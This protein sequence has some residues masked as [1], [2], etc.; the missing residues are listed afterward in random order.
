M[1]DKELTQKEKDDAIAAEREAEAAFQKEQ[2]AKAAATGPAA[3]AASKAADDARALKQ[4]TDKSSAGTDATP[5][6][7]DTSALEAKIAKQRTD[8]EKDEAALQK[9][10]ESQFQ[11]HAKATVKLG[12]VTKIL[13]E[14]GDS[15]TGKPVHEHVVQ[16]GG[17]GALV[18]GNTGGP[19]R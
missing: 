12:G 6:T 15:N 19:I 5:E 2:K 16:Q 18:E 11:K 13:R 10:K 4:A 9:A 14:E 17:G 1:P 8:L 7:A 3:D